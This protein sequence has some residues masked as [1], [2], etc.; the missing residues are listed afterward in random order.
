[1]SR[2]NESAFPVTDTYTNPR[3]DMVQTDVRGGLTIREH[4]AAMAMQGILASGAN[5]PHANYVWCA[6]RAVVMADA[7]IAELAKVRP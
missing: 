5:E 2:A 1:M 3:D 4:F 6:N 7:L